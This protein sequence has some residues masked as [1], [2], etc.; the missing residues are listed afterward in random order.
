MRFLTH[1][2]ITVA[3][4]Y[5]ASLFTTSGADVPHDPLFL[6]HFFLVQLLLIYLPFGKFLHIP[7]VFYSRTLLAKDY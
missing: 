7:G 1:F 4:T 6:L 3:Q 2:D 5:F